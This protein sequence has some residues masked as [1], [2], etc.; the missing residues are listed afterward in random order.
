M[1]QNRNQFSSVEYIN[2]G[3][4]ERALVLVLVMLCN[5]G[6]AL[7]PPIIGDTRCALQ[8]IAPSEAHLPKRVFAAL[9]KIKSAQSRHDALRT[10]MELLAARDDEYLRDCKWSPR[11]PPQGSPG[12][13]FQKLVSV[14]SFENV[15]FEMLRPQSPTVFTEEAG[16]GTHQRGR[17]FDEEEDDDMSKDKE[18]SP[19]DDSEMEEEAETGG[20]GVS[21]E[22]AAKAQM[23]QELL[24]NEQEKQAVKVIVRVLKA[25]KL[26]RLARFFKSLRYKF[27][28]KRD[29][30]SIA[31]K[32]ATDWVTKQLVEF[33]HTRKRCTICGVNLR[34]A[35]EFR[36]DHEDTAE[37]LD[38]DETPK[39][40]KG[41]CTH[42]IPKMS[43]E[44]FKSLIYC[45][46]TGILK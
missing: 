7:P 34:D 40:E 36:S 18:G 31:E 13:E 43:G 24:Q 3:E 33:L 12:L 41:Q 8:S 6:L 39:E 10:L 20:L 37:A 35:Q 17:A 4:A 44:D 30:Q 23:Q 29:A 9:C 1:N 32:A 25:A 21:R 5:A 22:E 11:M 28:I 16:D 2:T 26:I 27:T 38:E 45:R 46:N 42:F 19:V 15:Q 14:R